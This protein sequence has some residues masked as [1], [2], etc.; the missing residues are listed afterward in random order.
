MN[1]FNK[2]FPFLNFYYYK[3][4][5]NPSDTSALTPVL[6]MVASVVNLFSA[7]LRSSDAKA[8]FDSLPDM[9]CPFPEESLSEPKVDSGDWDEQGSNRVADVKIKQDVWL[10]IKPPHIHRS[11]QA[12]EGGEHPLKDACDGDS[13]LTAKPWVEGGSATRCK[14]FH[15]FVQVVCKSK[16]IINQSKLWNWLSYRG[17]IQRRRICIVWRDAQISAK[18]LYWKNKDLF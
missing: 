18:S 5:Y 8:F 12:I 1:Y 6:S 14:A 17:L 4:L 7:G 3:P 16:Y 2:W 15:V 13:N 11:P 10:E 9:N